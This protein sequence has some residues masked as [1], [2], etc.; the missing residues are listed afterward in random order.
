MNDLTIKEFGGSDTML[1]VVTFDKAFPV[2]LLDDTLT[3]VFP[4]TVFPGH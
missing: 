1:A 3:T 4:I 2:F